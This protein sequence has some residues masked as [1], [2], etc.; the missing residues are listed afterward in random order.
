MTVFTRDP[1]SK[2]LVEVSVGEGK[3]KVTAMGIPTASGIIVSMFGGEKPHIGAVAIAIPRPSL[4]DALKISSTSS[5]FTLMSHK[6]DQV[7]RPTAEKLARE[8]KEVVV[9]V[10]GIH[11]EKAT[12]EDIKILVKNSKKTINKL[13]RELNKSMKESQFPMR[14]YSLPI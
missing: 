12:K 13:K 7:A 9:V 4:E 5:V 6:D 3:Y 11:I 2:N 8:L 14:H 10:A 1:F